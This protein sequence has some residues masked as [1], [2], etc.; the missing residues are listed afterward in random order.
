VVIA[1]CRQR[2]TVDQFIADAI[3]EKLGREPGASTSNPMQASGKST[4]MGAHIQLEDAV[5][6]S[7][8]L[9]ELL[10][11]ETSKN[12]QAAPESVWGSF[13]AGLVHLAH[14]VSCELNDAFNLSRKEY[15]ELHRLARPTD[16]RRAA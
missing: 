15:A 13:G 4:R 3:R 6:K 5:Y 9:L 1:A 14:T 10:A 8:A 2:V 11:A 12:D 16:Q 7:V